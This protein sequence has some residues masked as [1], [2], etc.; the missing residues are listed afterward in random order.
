MRAI[1][2]HGSG[3]AGMNGARK[4][5]IVLLGFDKR[6]DRVFAARLGIADLL[7][8][9]PKTAAELARSTDTRERS[10]LRL[11]RGLVNLG[12]CVERAGVLSVVTPRRRSGVRCHPLGGSPADWPPRN[13]YVAPRELIRV[14]QSPAAL[15]LLP[16]PPACQRTRLCFHSLRAYA[17]N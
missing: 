10:L 14:V 17:L 9:G 2:L 13:E 8:A 15:S 5:R 16:L 6:V 4:M 11:M 12:I 3:S 1:D 7:A